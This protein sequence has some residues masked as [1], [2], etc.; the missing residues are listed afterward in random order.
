LNV[1]GICYFWLELPRN[2]KKGGNIIASPGVA[3][4]ALLRQICWLLP[5]VGGKCSVKLL[6]RAASDA[7]AA[8]M[9]L[10]MV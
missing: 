4:R 5:C 8:F 1:A 10:S 2:K 7:M 6:P 9:P 3:P